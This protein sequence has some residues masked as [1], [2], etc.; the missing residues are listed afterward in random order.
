MKK[1]LAGLAMAAMLAGQTTSAVAAPRASA[2]VEDAEK[3][4]QDYLLFGMVFAAVVV[5]VII[6]L[7]NDGEDPETIPGIGPLPVSP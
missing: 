2:P 5:G 6:A 3:L 7:S 1:F 4:S